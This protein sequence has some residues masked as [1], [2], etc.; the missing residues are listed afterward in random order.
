MATIHDLTVL[1]DHLNLELGNAARKGT[2]DLDDTPEE[3]VLEPFNR[4]KRSTGIYCTKGRPF[5]ERS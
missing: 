1:T 5:M 3:K 4:L 2:F